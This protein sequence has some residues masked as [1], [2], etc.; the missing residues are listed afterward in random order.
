[1]NHR[2]E[3]LSVNSKIS[4]TTIILGAVTL[5]H[6][7]IKLYEH[8]GDDEICRAQNEI[9]SERVEEQYASPSI[10]SLELDSPV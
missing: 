10:C 1:M 2:S 7:D 4:W 9:N 3:R 6:G 5:S 8:Y